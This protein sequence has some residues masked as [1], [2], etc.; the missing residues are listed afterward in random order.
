MMSTPKKNVSPLNELNTDLLSMLQIAAFAVNAKGEVIS[1]S[2]SME[3]LTGKSKDE[4]LGKKAWT[5]FFA[6]RRKTPVEMTLQTEEEDLDEEFEVTNLATQQKRILRFA[7]VPVRNANE[8]ITGAL[9]YL[10]ES[11]LQESIDQDDLVVNGIKAIH[12][13]VII[14]NKNKVVNFINSAAAKFLGK[15]A[16]KVVGHSCLELVKSGKLGNSVDALLQ[17]IDSG[18]S[19]SGKVTIESLEADADDELL[20]FDYRINPIFNQEQQL[21]GA[22]QTVSESVDSGNGV[23]SLRKAFS[24]MDQLLSLQVEATGQLSQ[25]SQLMNSKARET[26][27]QANVVSSASDQV[28]KSIETVAAAIEEM[29]LSITEIAKN[30]IEAANVANSA[31]KIADATNATIGK[32]GESSAKIGQVLKVINNIAEQTNLLAL[33]ATIEAARAGDAGRGFAVVANEVKELAKETAKATDD[34]SQRIEAIQQDTRRAVDAIEQVSAIIHQ[35]DDIANIIASAV[36]EQTATAGEISGSIN[37][38]ANGSLEIAQNIS[39]VVSAAKGTSCVAN[40]AQQQA[41]QLAEFS[42]ELHRLMS[43]ARN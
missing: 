43:R 34:I 9:A 42:K 23:E 40:E 18:E 3:S 33:N 35:I 2:D 13:P 21:L 5:A 31:V 27:G 11:S 41:D 25:G 7:A 20:I 19:T 37:E 1:W 28:K 24:R 30:A 14:I 10:Q 4:M 29:R 32:L 8:E 12:L 39:G 26:V 6:K 36:E 15:N 38:A 17:T 22:I 16:E